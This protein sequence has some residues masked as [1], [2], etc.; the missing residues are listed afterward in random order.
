MKIYKIVIAVV[1]AVVL[2]FFIGKGRPLET[3]YEDLYRAE[4]DNC[5]L[6]SQ[7]DSLKNHADSISRE[8]YSYS[9][10]IH[11]LMI[12]IGVLNKK[13]SD[14]KNRYEKV[15]SDLQFVSDSELYRIWSDYLK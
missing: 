6:L 12:D 15:I 11:E 2:G 13:L 4:R 3:V 9:D 10:V 14:N 1:L 5:R 7:C 8:I